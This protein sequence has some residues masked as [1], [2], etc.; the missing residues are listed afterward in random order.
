MGTGSFPGV[1]RLG[2]G[3]DNLPL[4]ATRLRMDLNSTSVY[5]LCH[6]RHVMGWP[7][8]LRR[9]NYSYIENICFPGKWLQYNSLYLDP[10]NSPWQFHVG[11]HSVLSTSLFFSSDTNSS[12]W[13]CAVHVS[14]NCHHQGKFDT[15]Q[16]AVRSNIIFPNIKT[17]LKTSRGFPKDIQITCTK[18]IWK[19]V[20]VLTWKTP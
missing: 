17:L 18:D 3:A 6:H 8:P 12:I 9:T 10:V 1:K 16:S 20:Q 13:T 14:A 5:P 19:S 7:L 15:Q 2:R 4:L 11:T